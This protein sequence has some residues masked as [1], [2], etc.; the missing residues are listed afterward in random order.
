MKRAINFA[1]EQRKGKVLSDILYTDTEDEESAIDIVK[2]YIVDNIS[3]NIQRDELAKRVYLNPDY[4]SKLFRKQEG[5]TIGEYILNKRM[6]LAQQLLIYTE[7]AVA[8]IGQKVGMADASY[9]IKT[10]KKYTG[11]TPQHYREKNNE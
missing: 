6:M 5:I 7:L 3:V 10:F 2:K 4:L 11:F 8:D 1:C 9:F